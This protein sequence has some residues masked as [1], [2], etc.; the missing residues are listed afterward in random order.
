MKSA[1]P[2]GVDLAT[3]AALCGVS[4]RS[5]YEL[6]AKSGFPKPLAGGGY[7]LLRCGT[8]FIKRQRAELARR[9]ASDGPALAAAKLALLSAQ[10]EKI[11]TVNRVVRGE[12]LEIDSLQ[13]LWTR[14][15]VNT[16]RR[17]RAIPSSI[18]PTLVNKADPAKCIAPLRAAIEGAL[19][20]LNGS[21]GGDVKPRIDRRRRR[22][23]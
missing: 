15:V 3:V 4:I 18:G 6:K 7:P 20:E 5:I 21:A 12:L 8:W 14:R 17:L 1:K 9:G 11:T 13:I 19:H 2:Q 23:V 22:N 10:A 16:Q